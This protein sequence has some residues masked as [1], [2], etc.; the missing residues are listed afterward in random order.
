[1]A[2]PR[3]ELLDS[4]LSFKIWPGKTVFGIDKSK[5]HCFSLINSLFHEMCAV[6]DLGLYD[7]KAPILFVLEGVEYPAELRL[8][9][10]DRSK[11]R[12]LKPEDLPM[13]ELISVQWGGFGET[14]QMFENL[15]P[16]C[17]ERLSLGGVNE[18]DYISFIYSGG[19]RFRLEVKP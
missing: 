9:I 14:I 8:V 6:F 17:H 18:E 4:P 15:L 11:T 12:R 16:N 2:P 3:P 1:M 13:R 10:Q 5:G 19:N 7:R